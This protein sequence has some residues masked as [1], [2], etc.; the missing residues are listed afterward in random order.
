MSSCCR[1]IGSLVVGA[2]LLASQG[3]FGT[4]IYVVLQDPHVYKALEGHHGRLLSFRAR[5]V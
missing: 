3:G 5:K 4:N 1:T 2:T